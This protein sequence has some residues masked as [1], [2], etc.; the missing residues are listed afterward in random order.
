M[1]IYTGQ[2]ACPFF[3]NGVALTIGNFDGVHLGHCQILRQLRQAADKRG[4]PTAIMLFEPQPLEYFS[5]LKQQQ[6]P[7]RLTPLRDKLQLLDNGGLIDAAWVLRFNHALSG[8]SA[9]DFIAKILI[10]GLNIKYLLVGDDFRFGSKRQGDFALLQQQTAFA[11]EQVQT[12]ELQ[13]K[14]ASSTAV[15]EALAQ[16][17]LSHAHR[18]L[19]RAY[20]ISGRV[21]HGKKLGRTI[22]CPTANIYLPPHHYPLSGVYVVEVTGDFGKRK[23][24]ANFGY[25][26]TVSDEIKQHL[27]VHLFDFNGDLYGKRLTVA[28]FAKLRD[29][30]KFDNINVLKQQIEQDIQQARHWQ[31]D[32]PLP[33][34][35]CCSPKAV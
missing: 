25:N 5:R 19:G 7:Y 3:E 14:R 6:K 16:G 8:I 27:E 9:D 34:V 1:K 24:V 20:A 17:D 2:S 33:V 26:P 11:T 35:S 4:L 23:G 32:E 21:M 12:V 29:E 15:R 22:G 31:A 28:F 30:Q 13:G 10:K 18:L